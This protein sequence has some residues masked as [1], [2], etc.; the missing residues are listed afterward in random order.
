MFGS[1]FFSGI[2]AIV[3]RTLPRFWQNAEL[4]GPSMTYQWSVD[5]ATWIPAIWGLSETYAPSMPMESV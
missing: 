3:L 5:L 4:W 2:N 1:T